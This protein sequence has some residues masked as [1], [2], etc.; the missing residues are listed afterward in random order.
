M[1]TLPITHPIMKNT[2]RAKYVDGPWILYRS[3]R[4]LK[5][6]HALPLRQSTQHL[7]MIHPRSM[8]NA[9]ETIQHACKDETRN[10]SRQRL[11][12]SC[13]SMKDRLMMKALA[14]IAGVWH[15][16][17]LGVVTARS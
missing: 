16:H 10:Y 8:L 11:I 6:D 13:L 12:Y 9:E 5:I 17:D 4:G 7:R 1:P 14:W 2:I 3:G 15:H